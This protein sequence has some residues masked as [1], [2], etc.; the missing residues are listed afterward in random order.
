M[1]ANLSRTLAC[2]V[3]AFTL[4]SCSEDSNG[5]VAQRA[6]WN[7]AYAQIALGQMY[8]D[9]DGV[10]QDRKE[11]AKWWRKAAQQGYADAQYNLG[12][13]YYKGEGV[14]QDFKEAVK[15]NRK[16]AEQGYADAQ[17]NL[18]LMYS[19]GEGVIQDYIQA[20]AWYDVSSAN[21]SKLGAKNRDLLAKQMS[22]E[23]IAKAQELAKEYFEKY[24][25]ENED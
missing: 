10:L 18:G 21:G 6:E 17:N 4:L 7:D 11:A 12:V 9:G 24:Q 1:I 23:Q 2:A 19:K 25:P 14:I 20:H 3:L 22:P 5:T 13:M 15:W 8:Y 16:A